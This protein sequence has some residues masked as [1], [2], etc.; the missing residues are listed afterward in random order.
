MR[1]N[2]KL[3]LGFLLLVLLCNTPF[4]FAQA[5][6][7][8]ITCLNKPIAG[9]YSKV[10][11][12]DGITIRSSDVVDDEALFIAADKINMMLAKIPVAK[13]NLAQWGAEIHIIGRDQ[14]TSDLPEFADQKGVSFIDNLGNKTDIDQRTRG[15]GGIYTSCGEENLLGLP[16]DRYAGGQDICI[17]E[18]AHNIMY[19]GL[20]DNLREAITKQYRKAKAAGLWKDAYAM[21][22]AGEYWAELSMWYF[23]RH[24]EFLKGTR[25]PAIGFAA[26]HEYDKGGYELLD[27]IYSGKAVIKEINVAA[28][29]KVKHGSVTPLK[30]G[31]DG[32]TA[33]M[34]TNNTA[35]KLK[36]YWLDYDGVAKQ[37]GEATAHNSFTYPTYRGHIWEVRDT[38]GKLMGRYRMNKAYVRAIVN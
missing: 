26:L 34:V 28:A 32:E 20:G 14:Q 24:G 29:Q 27:S 33:F 23:G 13:H 10:L 36:L 37:H 6:V 4:L 1:I 3:R 12:V 7:P 2:K 16:H 5:P 31:P 8:H 21:V 35:K 19:Y 38:K 9:F 22:D 15:L 30:G 17:H 18:F 11:N 25:S